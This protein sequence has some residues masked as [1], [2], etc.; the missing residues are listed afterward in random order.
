RLLTVPH[1]AFSVA[2]T[3]QQSP[4]LIIRQ[5]ALRQGVIFLLRLNDWK[6]G[7]HLSWRM[8][9]LTDL[10]HCNTHHE[11]VWNIEQVTHDEKPNNPTGCDGGEPERQ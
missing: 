9:L 2:R 8:G 5:A 3:S 10:L 4:V 6:T 1:S 11:S 7:R